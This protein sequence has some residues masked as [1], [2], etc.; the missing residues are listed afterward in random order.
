MTTI[1][2][3]KS[4][5]TVGEGAFKGIL[6]GGNLGLFTLWQAAEGHEWAKSCVTFVGVVLHAL[7]VV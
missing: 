3:V 1:S 5:M 4:S 2:E 7:G 6:I